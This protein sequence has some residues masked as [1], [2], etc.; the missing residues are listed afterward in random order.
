MRSICVCI[1]IY[2]WQRPINYVDRRSGPQNTQK[3]SNKGAY[4]IRIGPIWKSLVFVQ[5][6]GGA[7]NLKRNVEWLLDNSIVLNVFLGWAYIWS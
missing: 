3:Y 1:C 5:F 2:I 7:S 4:W 6:I